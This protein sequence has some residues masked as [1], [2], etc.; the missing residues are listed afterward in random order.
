MKAKF[1]HSYKKADSKNPGQ[2]K[3]VYVYAVSG[4]AAELAAYKT[5]QA[6]QFR[7]DE[8]GAPLWFTTKVLPQNVVLAISQK[9]GKIYADTSEGDKINNLANQYPGLLGQA[10]AQVGATQLLSKIFGTAQPAVTVAATGSESL[11]A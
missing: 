8:T 1:T 5:A 3:D 2:A 6:E 11:E 9:S 4:T 10:I 7:E